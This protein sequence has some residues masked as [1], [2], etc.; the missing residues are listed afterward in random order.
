MVSRTKKNRDDLV[1]HYDS[2]LISFR[3]DGEGGNILGHFNIKETNS[4]TST[5]IPENMLV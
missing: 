3:Q 5:K 1:H 2:I 4:P